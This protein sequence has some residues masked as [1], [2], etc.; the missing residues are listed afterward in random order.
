M[1]KTNITDMVYIALIGAVYAVIT[2]L[3][4]P[5]SYGVIQFRFSEII[6]ATVLK[7]KKY[8]YGLGLGVFLSNT[9]STVGGPLDWYVMPIVQIF[10][11]LVAYTIYHKI[12]KPHMDYFAMIVLSAII[13]SGVGFVLLIALGIPYIIGFSSVFVSQVIIN[14][15]SVF[16]IKKIWNRLP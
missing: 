16:I 15:F 11:G 1:K 5:I 4:A 3:F 6:Q 10:A 12:N 2:I 9:L 13:A 14:M 7:D 8:I